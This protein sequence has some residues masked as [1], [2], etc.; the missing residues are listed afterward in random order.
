VSFIDAGRLIANS[1]PEDLRRRYSAGYRIAVTVSGDSRAALARDLAALGLAIEPAGDGLSARVEALPP[2]V[3][4]GLG[5]L[6][7]AYPAARIHLE[8]PAMPDVFRQVV[9]EAR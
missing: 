2:A 9:A 1:T 4:D 7:A 8:Q 5:R 6:A 3:L